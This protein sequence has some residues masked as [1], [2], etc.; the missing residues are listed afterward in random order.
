MRKVTMIKKIKITNNKA[1]LS[2]RDTTNGCVYPVIEV[3]EGAKCSDGSIV[4]TDGLSFKDDV[5]DWV[6]IF[7]DGRGYE[8]VEEDLPMTNNDWNTV[9][10]DETPEDVDAVV[11]FKFDEPSYYKEVDGELQVQCY[12]SDSF[13]CSRR[14]E[15]DDVIEYFGDRFHLRPSPTS[16]PTVEPTPEPTE[17]TQVETSDVEAT[18]TPEFDWSSV[19]EDV[20]AVIVSPSGHLMVVLKEC[21]G[22]LLIG[23]GRGVEKRMY[24]TCR[25]NKIDEYPVWQLQSGEGILIRRPLATTTPE[26]DMYNIFKGVDNKPPISTILLEAQQS[27][28]KHHG[29]T[30]KVKFTVTC[31]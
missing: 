7:E 29:V 25:A 2:L 9:D 5:G 23:S 3:P 28:L 21:D 10:W 26:V 18:T 6:D 24:P 13:E 12:R 8:V 22:V 11:T 20:E 27:I 30:G 31:S 16:Q 1:R 4:V 14:R 19:D 15:I 17:S